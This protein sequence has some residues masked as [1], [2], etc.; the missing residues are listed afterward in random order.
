MKGNEPR[1]QA[2]AIRSLSGIPGA[3]VT[4]AL[5]QS[6]ASLGELAKIQALAALSERGDKSALPFFVT[7]CNDAAQPVRAAALLELGKIG[8][9]SVIALLAETAARNAGQPEARDLTQIRTGGMPNE[10]QIGPAGGLTEAA[11]ARD[12]LY[13]LRGAGIDQAILAAIPS[14]AAPVKVELINATSE[15]GMDAA[16][17]VLLRSTGD[18]DREVRRAA[19][20]ALRNTAAPSDV[21]ALLDLLE[22]S[23]PA[24]RTDVARVVSSALR[25][26]DAASVSP[27]MSAYQSTP[28]KELRGAL[29]AVLAQVGRDE[30]LP[31]LRDALKES[32]VDLRRGAIRAL[33]E[34][35]NI[36]PMPEL[37]SVAKNEANPAL[38]ALALQGY[39]RLIGLPDGRLPPVTVRML[40][41]AMSMA[42][43]PEE[44]RA[45]LSM[46][47][48]L[49][50]AEA[51][52]LAEAAAKDPEVTSEANLAAE[53]IRQRLAP[54]RRQ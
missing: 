8:D 41:E 24:E 11:A 14:A 53:R 28:D 31:V 1:I 47:Q 19:L 52:A 18:A 35:P 12:S 46:V 16:T 4:A 50:V 32:D 39:I 44:K 2:Q 36:T 29:L 17:P 6:M 25:R 23:P 10:R 7:A 5:G 37:A 40:S 22:K 3:D 13:R 54:R 49:P 9:A 15:R 33:G 38:Q 20:R 43:R 48:A 34:W 26:S 30:S 27:V 45:V 51:L 21:P 42:K